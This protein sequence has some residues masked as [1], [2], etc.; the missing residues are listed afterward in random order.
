MNISDL[1][2]EI[3]WMITIENDLP[4]R[5]GE[6]YELQLN[7]YQKWIRKVLGY[8]QGDGSFESLTKLR[9]GVSELIKKR[10]LPRTV[11]FGCYSLRTHLL[12]TIDERI[13]A[14][15]VDGNPYRSKK[16]KRKIGI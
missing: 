16:F 4:E 7:S 1:L 9:D 13:R 15:K 10:P 12:Q 8:I 6:D 3:D 5:T 2:E 14:L 11:P